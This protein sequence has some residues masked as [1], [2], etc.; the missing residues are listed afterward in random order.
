VPCSSLT[1]EKFQEDGLY[2]EEF[3]LNEKAL[4]PESGDVNYGGSM[5]TNLWVIPDKDAD[6]FD[7]YQNSAPYAD[8]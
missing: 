1:H 5:G 3:S 6:E 7:I 2:Y 4:C 8:N